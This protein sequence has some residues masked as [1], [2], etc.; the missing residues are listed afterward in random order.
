MKSGAIADDDHADSRERVGRWAGWCE[1][2]HLVHVAALPAFANA[3]ANRY[4]SL[5]YGAL[6]QR[7]LTVVDW[8][9]KL[10]QAG[11]QD[12]V[13]V[14][15]PEAALNKPRWSRA[16]AR[17]GQ[18]VTALAAARARGARVVWTA[19]NLS[20]HGRLHPRSEA[21]FWKVF[22]RQVDGWI[23]LTEGSVA[24][25]E[26]AHPRLRSLPRT[27]TPHGHYRGSYPDTVTRDQARDRLGLSAQHRV[28]ACIG[29]I[30]AYKGAEELLAAM[31]QSPD[32]ELRLLVAG[33]CDDTAL[34]D[35]LSSAAAQDSRV[36]L[37]LE[38]IADGEL[39]F[40][41]RAADLAVLPYVDV[42]NSGSA[43]LALSF[44]LPVL[45]PGL[46]A[47]AE[48]E[49]A[50]PGWVQTYRGPLTTDRVDHALRNLP[51]GRP[52]LT[53]YDWPAIATRTLELYDA[54][55]GATQHPSRG[56]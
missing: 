37:H 16:A 20:S 33:R 6:Q 21:A 29:R 51:T 36:T 23:A 13:H 17:T 48:L 5:L 53:A 15:W 34:A 2:L 8:T 14:H 56:A 46:G 41:L 10:V 40:W 32:K 26:A 38:A 31:R 24:A 22:D 12:I 52:D 44:D 42:L 50:V 27:V 55:R 43:M 19:H 3:S 7:G 45:A 35:R 1:R 25:I 39:Q 11:G 9:P 28:I 30:K 4:N 54:V 49:D 18:M 47:I